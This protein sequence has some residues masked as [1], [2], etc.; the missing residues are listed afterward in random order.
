MIQKFLTEYD[1]QLQDCKK[2]RKLD[3]RENNPIELSPLLTCLI[4]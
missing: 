4:V 2:K 1:I 3:R